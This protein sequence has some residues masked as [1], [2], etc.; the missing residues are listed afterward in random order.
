MTPKLFEWTWL[1]AR[2]TI[3]AAELSRA[4]AMSAAELDELVEYGALVPVQTFPNC[5]FSAACVAPL[6]QASRLREDFELDL[7]TVAMVLGY[8]TRIDAL[9][10]QLQSLRAHLPG[11]VRPAS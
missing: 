8:L 3:D 4:C 1:D 6:R 7:F 11:H 9:E 10:Q 5:V 2:E